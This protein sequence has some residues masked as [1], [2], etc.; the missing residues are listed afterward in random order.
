MRIHAHVQ[1]HA[2]AAIL[3]AEEQQILDLE[4]Q[5]FRADL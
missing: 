1:A 2:A 3:T 4:Q 5:V